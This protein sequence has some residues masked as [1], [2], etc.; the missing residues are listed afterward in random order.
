MVFQVVFRPRRAGLFG[1]G[2]ES[3]RW[4]PLGSFTFHNPDF[5]I[6]QLVQGSITL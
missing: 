2:Y 3:W 6:A 5:F 4:K 1:Q